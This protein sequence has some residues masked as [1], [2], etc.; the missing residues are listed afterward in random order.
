MGC[1]YLWRSRADSFL[2]QFICFR[3]RGRFVRLPMQISGY[4]IIVT[5][6]DVAIT[7]K[8]IYATA[9]VFNINDESTAL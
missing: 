6:G 8:N 3:Q 2:F 4:D 7:L 5:V 9:D 1:R